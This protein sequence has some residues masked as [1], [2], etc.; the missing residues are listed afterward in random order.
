MF[1]DVKEAVNCP[2]DY[3]G[4]TLKTRLD[5]YIECEGAKLTFRTT[6]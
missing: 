3:Q 4:K 1:K 2:K 5:K 6:K